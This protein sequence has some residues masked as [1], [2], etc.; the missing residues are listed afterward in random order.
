MHIPKIYLIKRSLTPEQI[1]RIKE[2]LLVTP[3]SAI[4]VADARDINTALEL[5]DK[6]E[7]LNQPIAILA[8]FD[9]VLTAINPDGS[10]CPLL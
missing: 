10:L 4:V 7:V 6:A 8:D 1:Q 5:S 2:T 3:L 9:S